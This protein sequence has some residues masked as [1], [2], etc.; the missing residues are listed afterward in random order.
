MS[1]LLLP[2]VF[3]ALYHI[4]DK[5]RNR[6]MAT[7][8]AGCCKHF[9]REFDERLGRATARAFEALARSSRL[10]GHLQNEILDPFPRS[11]LQFYTFRFSTLP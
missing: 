2:I 9:G 8:G 10:G 4:D 3:A 5:P 7:T 1:S 6:C 11:Q